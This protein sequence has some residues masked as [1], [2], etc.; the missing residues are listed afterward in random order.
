MQP[1]RCLSP[2][3]ALHEPHRPGWLHR[4]GFEFEELT[5]DA[6]AVLAKLRR[7]PQERGW[8]GSFDRAVK[9]V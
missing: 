5:A 6:A 9:R 4:T 7:K 3:P 1:Y 2:S 8:W